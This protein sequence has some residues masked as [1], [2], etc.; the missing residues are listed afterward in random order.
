[1]SS[2]YLSLRDFHCSPKLES[3]AQYPQ[4]KMTKL[5]ESSAPAV[6]RYVLWVLLASVLFT[7]LWLPAHGAYLIIRRGS[8]RPK[9]PL[10]I[11]N[12]DE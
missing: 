10:I 3:L 4:H 6:L 12:G 2:Y 7:I 8:S 11:E 1:M 9:L 5:H